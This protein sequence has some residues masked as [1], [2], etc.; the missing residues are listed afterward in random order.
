MVTVWCGMSSLAFS[1]RTFFKTSTST[2]VAVMS[3]RYVTILDDFLLPML[4][5]DDIDLR[6]LW[7]QNSV[8]CLVK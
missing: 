3:K 6:S 5:Q 2:T 8:E 7:F 1:D 4:R